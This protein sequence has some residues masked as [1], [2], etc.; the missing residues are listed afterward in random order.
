MSTPSIAISSN[1]GERTST[2][3]AFL[4]AGLIMSAW[5]PLVPL[6]KERTGLDDGGLGLLLLGLGLGSIAA[7]PFAGHLTAR[8]GCRPVIVWSTVVLCAVLTLLTSIAWLPGLVLAVLLFGASMG[9]LD[10]AMNIQSIIVEKNSG[11]ALQSS[12]HGMYSVGGI[13]GAGALTVLLSVGLDP[14][15]AVLCIVAIVMGA[16]YLSLIHI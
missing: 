16:L 4:I 6:A 11:E 1:Y 13:L 3:I 14:V 12:F 7:M 8:Y 5:A 15:L 9:M 10:C 2:R